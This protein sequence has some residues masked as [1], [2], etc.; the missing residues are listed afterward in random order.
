MNKDTFSGFHP[1]VNLAFFAAALGMTMFIL[2]PVY[3]LISFV[4]ACAYLLYFQG[5]K[6]MLRQVG[7]LV[8][9][10][11]LM[12]ILNPLTSGIGN[13]SGST[14]VSKI[15][16]SFLKA[17]SVKNSTH[18]TL[19][20]ISKRSIQR[21]ITFNIKKRSK[22]LLLFFAFLAVFLFGNTEIN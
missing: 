22:N 2:Q 14:D 18:H 21:F 7:Y 5:K 4:S 17:H 8:P 3:L 15:P 10:L 13:T 12:A 20:T 11:I 1:A 9:L 6:G 16:T 19:Q